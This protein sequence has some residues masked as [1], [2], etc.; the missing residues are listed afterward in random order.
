MPGVARRLLGLSLVAA[1]GACA[2]T[3][4]VRP[5]GRGN[6]AW[7]AS[8]GGPM[9]QALGADIPTPILTVGGAY[10]AR[11]DMEITARADVTAAAYGDL[12]LQP[13]VAYHTPLGTGDGAPILTAA[14]SLHLITNFVDTRVYPQ[15]TLVSAWPIRRRHS[16]YL[17][18]DAGVGFG[19]RARVIAGPLLGGEL[20]AGRLGVTLEGKW[21]APY[22]DVAPTAPSWI[23]P[24]GHGYL[25][26]LV[27]VTYYLGGAP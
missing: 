22:Y 20:R 24:F 5:I 11:N 12:H 1:V 23:S 6:T 26:V 10:G 27:G 14:P 7:N 4:P 18:G 2:T 3:L 17:G 9:V 15:L 13:G 25:A 8:V 16:L 21:L 19:A